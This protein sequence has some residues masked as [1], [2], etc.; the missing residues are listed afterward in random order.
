MH[1]YRRLVKGKA[2]D[3]LLVNPKDMQS[4]KLKDGDEVEL[5][6]AAGAV[7]VTVLASDEM[8]PG[9]VSLPHGY[10]HNRRGAQLSIASR[11]AGVSCNDVT[12]A[13]YLDELSG[14]AAVNG[15]AVTLGVA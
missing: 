3:Q 10:G 4:R 1:N 14:N 2:R 11:H 15:V 13:A 12:D 7:T 6:S 9:V 5:R 8:M